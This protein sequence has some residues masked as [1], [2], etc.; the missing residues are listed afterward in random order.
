MRTLTLVMIA[1]SLAALSGCGTAI[2]EG[3]GKA[4]G[5]E[6]VVVPIHPSTLSTAEPLRE[7][8]RFELGTFT[9]DIAGQ[10]PADL[11]GQFRAHF[12]EMLAKYKV[13]TGTG[14]KTLLIRGVVLN[15]EGSGS[16][17]VITSAVE[18]VVVRTELVDKESGRVLAT[19]NCI[20]RSTTRVNRGIDK[21]AEG[22]AKAVAKWIAKLQH[23]QEEPED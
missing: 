3:A 17:A 23:F 12:P 5:P 14:G 1:I 16:L 18:E 9:N 13:A 11:L 21:K 15:Y 22:L 7:Y 10:L 2:S 20:G 19:A 8:S 6:G 4:F